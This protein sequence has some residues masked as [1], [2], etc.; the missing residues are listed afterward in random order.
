MKTYN[1]QVTDDLTV[2]IRANSQEEAIRILKSEIAKK[3]ASPL[4]DKTDF[5]Y[6]TGITV[7]RLRAALAR[8]EIG[9]AH[10]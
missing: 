8:Q 3:E 6:E 4:F 2:P 9:R 10:V 5:D 7:P 1:L